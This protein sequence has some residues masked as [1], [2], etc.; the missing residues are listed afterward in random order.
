VK[1]PRPVSRESYRQHLQTVVARS[2]A[3]YGYT[4]TIW[5]AGAV[6]THEEGIP[7]AAEAIML[8]AGAVLGFALVGR[9][10]YGGVAQVVDPPLR[11]VRLWGSFHLP[12]VALSTGLATLIAKTIHGST[13]WPLVG[14]SATLTYLLA[15]ALQATLAEG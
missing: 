3:P 9:F 1:R 13:A 5:T 12:S 8:L 14:L 6:T 11:A 4:L 7:S 10:A 2:A 15:L